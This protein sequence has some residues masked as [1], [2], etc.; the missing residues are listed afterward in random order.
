MRPSS[1]QPYHTNT[2]TYTH[3]YMIVRQTAPVPVL[4][5]HQ[6]VSSAKRKI[7]KMKYVKWQ[8]EWEDGAFSGATQTYMELALKPT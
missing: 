7:R 8:L 1:A 3:M 4:N 5:L 2:S 6:F